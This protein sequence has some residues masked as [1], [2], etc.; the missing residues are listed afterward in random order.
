MYSV[1]SDAGKI[2]RSALVMGTKRRA[3]STSLEVSRMPFRAGSASASS[4]IHL[5]Q[6]CIVLESAA[7]QTA[8]CKVLVYLHH[9]LV[10]ISLF[11]YFVCPIEIDVPVVTCWGQY[12]L[13]S[14]ETHSL[15]HTHTQSRKCCTSEVL[16]VFP[17]IM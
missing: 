9:R 5:H 7:S 3:W 8:T 12:H 4:S 2:W 15:T 14:R 1:S 10:F 6:P 13:L 17:E 16:F 11:L